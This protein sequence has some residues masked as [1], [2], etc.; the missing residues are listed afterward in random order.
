MRELVFPDTIEYDRFTLV[1]GSRHGH[2]EMRGSIWAQDK[3]VSKYGLGLTDFV[4]CQ[5]EVHMNAQAKRDIARKQRILACAAAIGNVSKTC[6]YFGIPRRSSINGS[7]PM[8]QMERR[9]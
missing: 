8:K 9:R 1:L 3:K 5:P 2:E 6:R 4:H 7:A